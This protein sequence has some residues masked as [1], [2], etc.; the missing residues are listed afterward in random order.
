MAKV[1]IADRHEVVRR[2]VWDLLRTSGGFELCG[3]AGD[4][5]GAVDQARK[6][7][8]DVAVLDIALPGLNGIEVM[9]QL[10]PQTAV[11][12]LTETRSEDV[13]RDCLRAGALA[14]VLKSELFKDRLGAADND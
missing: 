9:R 4:G 10:G 7:A 5:R 2:G 13:V 3:D 14:Y 11:V 6:A 8:P 1:L 12:V